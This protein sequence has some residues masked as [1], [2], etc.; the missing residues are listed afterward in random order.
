MKNYFWLVCLL[1]WAGLV[2]FLSFS[3]QEITG[4]EPRSKNQNKQVY[5]VLYGV[6]WMIFLETFLIKNVIKNSMRSVALVAFVLGVPIELIQHLFTHYLEG[7]Y[8]DLSVNVLRMLLNVVLI[9]AYLKCFYSN[10]KAL[11]CI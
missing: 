10:T 9:K 4:I 7:Y 3:N 11:I 6:L 8:M 2:I 1:V 5:L